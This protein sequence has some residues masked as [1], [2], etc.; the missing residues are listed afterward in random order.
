LE[1]TNTSQNNLRPDRQHWRRNI[2]CHNCGGRGHIQREC[3]KP[4]V[5][6]SKERVQEK[7][8]STANLEQRLNCGINGYLGSTGLFIEARVENE[9][10]SLLVDT[11]A[12]LTIIS[13]KIFDKLSSEHHLDPIQKPIT[14]ASGEALT[15]YGRTQMLIRVGKKSYNISVA[16]ADIPMDGVLGLDFMS[17]NNCMINVSERRIVIG[18]EIIELVKSGHYGCYRIA[19]AE[20]INIPSRSEIVT[21]CNVVKPNDASLPKGVSLIEPDDE[22]L[23]S[24]RGLVGKVLVENADRVPVRIMN[25][26]NEVKVVRSGTVVANMTHI[27]NVIDESSVMK[28]SDNNGKL[29]PHLQNLLERSGSGLNNEQKQRVKT[30]LAR[31]SSLFASDDADLGRT[32]LVKHKIDT[33]TKYPIKQR[34]RRTPVHLEDTIHQHIDEMLDRNVIEKSSGPWASP[35]VLVRK[36]DGSTRFCVDYRKL[37]EATIKDAYPLPR[38]DET[39]DHLAGARW[40]STLDLLSGYWQ[41]EV[42]AKDRAKTAFITKRGLF[43]FKVMPFGLCNAPATFERLMDTVLSGLHWTTCLVYLD[44]IIVLGRSFEGMMANL[45]SVFTRLSSAGLKMKA[46][47]CSLFAREVE[48]LG[49]IISENGVSTDPKKI[50]AIKTWIEPTSVKDIRSFLGLCSYYRRFI[51]GF[52]TIAKPL[53]KLTHKNVKFVWSKECQEAFDSLKYHLIHSPIL[54]Y[55]DFGKSFILDTDA[56]DSGIGAVLS[57]LIDGE[58]RVVAYAS[59]TLSKTEQKYCVT[60]KELLSVV[61]YVKHFRHYLYGREFTVRTDH[62][63]LRWLMNFKDPEGQWARWL[64]TLAMFN[65][66]I[67]HRPGSQHRNA[68][69]L[70]RKPCK[71]CMHMYESNEVRSA[72]ARCNA[73]DISSIQ[74]SIEEEINLSDLQKKDVEIS[75]VRNWLEHKMRPEPLEFSSGGP[76]MKSLWSQRALL[77][78]KDDLLCRKWTDKEGYTLQAIV[79][80][81]ERR[82]VLNYSH[83]HKTAGHLGVTKTLS[84]IRQS[85]YWPGLQRDVR[86]YIAGCEICMKSKSPNHTLRAPMQLVGAGVPMERIAMDIVGELPR[87][88]KNNRYILVVSDYFTKWVEAFAMP[89]MEAATVADIVAKEVIARFGVPSAIHSDQGKQFEGKVFTEMCKVLNIKKT[90]TTPYHPQSDG[91]VE[92]FNKTLLSMLRTLVDEN[93][94]DWDELLPFVLMAYRSVEQETTG[95]SPNYLMFGREVATPLDVM[96]RMPNLTR[97]IPP[98]QW[99]WELKEKLESSHS[100]VRQHTEQAM[101]RQKS[102]HDQKLYWQSFQLGD[103]VYVYFPR[104]QVG[105]SPKLTKFWRGPFAVEA[106][107]SDLTYKVNCGSRGSSQVVHV[108]RMRL[109]RRQELAH[110]KSDDEES[111]KETVPEIIDEYDSKDENTENKSH[112]QTDKILNKQCLIPE[113]RLRKPPKWL[114]E[115]ETY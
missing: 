49:H 91:M 4:K 90:R 23:A 33:E 13:K 110:E 7:R 99:A 35:V 101:L 36:K 58:E 92:R 85:Y 93:Q 27:D 105:K 43:Q 73:L 106:K 5:N 30:F 64:E 18:E 20:N 82:R 74:E 22:F 31:H 109:K 40:Y 14:G 48:Y 38:I 72:T 52:A 86:Q 29:P 34:L 3:K 71:K 8:G 62:S 46:K 56:S 24:E 39:L 104:Y 26:S 21:Y 69:A 32:S 68:D 87:T 41:V 102:L 37:N 80:F 75:K 47:K 17:R 19:V 57:Q 111:S 95:C 70:S 28:K 53:H 59:R 50:E 114:S 84:R 83:D 113:T 107:L 88:D 12:S 6:L 77:E 79:P 63:S 112:E 78:V 44:D 108:D 60:R 96:Y 94:K 10:V 103:E 25:I 9:S 15:V 11:G 55:P 97:S 89:N 100:L 42:E 61:T 76:M 2:T 45:E 51:K 81:S 66:K 98:N 115:Y 54:A 67:E 16:I 65:M 1:T